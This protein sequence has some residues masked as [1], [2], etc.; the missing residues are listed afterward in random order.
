LLIAW[1]A[2]L[3]LDYILENGYTVEEV[4]RLPDQ[5]WEDP[6]QQ[7]QA[8]RFAGIDV[9]EHVGNN[10]APAIPDDKQALKYLNSEK[11]NHVLHY[12]GKGLA[13]K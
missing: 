5:P 3:A 4:A 7:P 8:D 2:V 12:G 1:V 13:W 9:W 6:R 11:V 10:L